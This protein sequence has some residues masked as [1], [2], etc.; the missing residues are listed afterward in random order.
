MNSDQSAGGTEQNP[1]LGPDGTC[2]DCEDAPP[3]TIARISVGPLALTVA[4]CEE[5]D[6]KLEEEFG[7]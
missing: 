7:S 1:Q 3:G 4:V 2:W 6:E 5:C